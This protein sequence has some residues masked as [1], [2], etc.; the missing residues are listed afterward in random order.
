M[1]YCSHC[2][3]NDVIPTLSPN[4]GYTMYVA[5]ES[6]CA[7]ECYDPDIVMLKCGDCDGITYKSVDDTPAPKPKTTKIMGKG[8][9]GKSPVYWLIDGEWIHKGWLLPQVQL[10]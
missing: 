8:G 1:N 9:D 7:T 2:G 5:E 10:S 3:S 4:A 6:D